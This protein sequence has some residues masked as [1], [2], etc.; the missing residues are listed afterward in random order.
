MGSSADQ[1]SESDRRVDEA[2]AAY[3]EA[4]EAGRPPP[5]GEFLAR[6]PDLAEEL[7]SFLDARAAFAGHAG[8][9]NQ[10]PTIA[11]GQ[12][13]AASGA[14]LGTVRYF[15]DY[16]L[17]AE[18]ARGGM[19]VVYK[20]RQ[21]SLNRVVALKMIL[22]GQL[23]SAADVARFR[24]EAEAA[25]KLDH[26]NIVP[27]YEVGEHEGQHYFSMKLIEGGSLAGQIAA[28]THRPREAARL[29]AVVARAVHHAHQR[30]IL[31]R[32]LKPGN[33]LIDA[34]GQPHVT[35][36][37]LARRVEGDSGLTQSGAIVGT[38]SYM[39]PEQA[40]AEK[41]LTTA[42]DVYSLGAILYELLTGQPPFRGGTPLETVMQVLDRDP[43]PPRALCRKLDRDLETI[44]LKC[45][46]KEPE[47]R[48]ESA[49]AL[50]DDL[51]RW[52][53]GEPILTR[54]VGSMGRLVKW[55][56]RRPAAAGLAAVS[57]LAVVTLLAGGLYFNFQLQEQ[58]RR[59]ETGEADARDN[60]DAAWANQYSAHMNLVASDLDNGNFGRALETL[61]LYRQPPVG[62]KDLRGWEWYFQQRLA[63]QEL[64]T[65]K[66]HRNAVLSV[67]FSP[68]GTR[69]ASASLLSV[70]KLWDVATGQE[71][72]TFEGPQTLGEN[73]SA[74]CVAFSPD[75]TRLASVSN[76]KL[77]TLRD[78]NTGRLLHFLHGH[79]G[80]VESVAFSPDGT[81]LASAGADRTIKLWDVATGQ[82]IRTLPGHRTP[83]HSVAFSPDGTR[84]A[85]ASND[86]TLK[87]WDARTGQEIRTLKG[88][89]GYEVMSVAFSP[90]GRQLASAGRTVKLWD[91]TTGEELRT[92]RGHTDAIRSV[93][94]SPD[95]SRLASAGD[96]NTVRLWDAR[97]GEVIRTFHVYTAE[98]VG[99]VMS[100]AFSP[101]G[102]R[103]A[104][105]HAD[106]TVR[107]WDTGPGLEV[108]TFKVY[109][110]AV[111][112]I[113]FSPKGRRLASAG[114][115][116]TI[117][118]WG[119]DRT[120]RLWDA[121]AGQELRTLQGHT[122]PV[123][124]A[125]FSPDGTR[126]ASASADGT[127]RV[128]DAG[129]GKQ[130]HQ[131]GHSSEV[132]DVAF[133]PDG[134]RLAAACEF[135]TVQ[136]W[137]AASGGQLH[138]LKVGHG[139]RSVAFSPNG[140][141]LAAGSLHYV[142]LWDAATGRELHRPQAGG[143]PGLWGHAGWIR[144]VAFSPNSAKLASAGDDRTV[145]LWDVATRRELRTLK[146]HTKAVWS[147]AFS[148]DG[149]RLASA[150]QD[151][152]VK[153]WDTATGAELFTLKGQTKAGGSVA[154]SAYGKRLAAAGAD[155]T[156]TLWDARPRGDTDVE[157]AL[158]L[159]TL[160]AK[161][162]PR[163]AVRT[164]VAKQLILT[165]AV[166]QKA[167]EL[168]DRFPEETDPQK[169][170]AAG[171]PLIRH[172][173]GNLFMAQAA[174]AQMKAAV[175]KAPGDDKYQRALGIAYYRLGRFQKEHYPAALAVLSK[176]AQDQPVTLAFLAMTQ[177]RLGHQ[178][179]AQATLTRLRALL[180]TPAW[181]KDQESQVFLAEAETLLR[182]AT[183]R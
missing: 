176:C 74:A 164:A 55:A 113:A 78:A 82:E 173:Y 93:A 27:I 95:G 166:R 50:A 26:P 170:H 127:V 126:L 140:A 85:S 154:F 105:G 155:G 171:W 152:T 66:G 115:D 38:P 124:T 52:L 145:K 72:R 69:L 30:G 157:A 10:I 107:L 118:L 9:A 153:L 101:D 114:D 34:Q 125:V 2:V 88:H 39:P 117:R 33:I 102:T 180:Q 110:G 8:P 73:S 144:S 14:V 42:I 41:H 19:G 129:T 112:S 137:H 141:L 80:E 22:A 100:V 28:L 162:L 81:C 174:L 79:G 181:A 156:V 150:S 51:E 147:L 58:V 67:A 130:L 68:D 4:L 97:T 53:R 182:P 48:Y 61:E 1:G 76:Q 94:F 77:V 83:V 20:A 146:G 89:P 16:E 142:Q 183:E 161:P 56:R 87:L 159:N 23:A 119:D 136:V 122:G 111:A 17:L 54:P 98:R 6:Y 148:P 169:Y 47:R 177:H 35:D 15:G 116:S 13:L 5:R 32:D 7:A 172:P 178:A 175:A 84:L 92:L 138:T 40:R 128:W 165:E 151:G 132:W 21:V 63:R 133:S 158:L 65:L 134:S 179:E 59:A 106:D 108:R 3:Y 91:A 167:L 60:A 62:R 71:L 45:L 103:L 109:R 104:T 96:D 121:V 37:G 44:C 49:A 75:G 163:S 86:T 43:A 64:R 149:A 25:G 46:H 12:T 18:I 120:I 131:L 70:V 135:A 160:Y 90:D 11:D 31:H 143:L 24:A 168:A 123:R 57:V 139:A 36:F 29:L 99:W